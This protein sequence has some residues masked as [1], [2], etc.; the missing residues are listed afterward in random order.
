MMN[1]IEVIRKGGSVQDDSWISNEML[2]PFTETRNTGRFRN[3]FSL[4]QHTRVKL[5]SRQLNTKVWEQRKV[6]MEVTE[7]NN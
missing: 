7:Y 6:W 5:S 2:V 4:R 1:W 3:E